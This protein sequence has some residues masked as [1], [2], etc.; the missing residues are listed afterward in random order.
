MGMIAS[1]CGES[2]GIRGESFMNQFLEA[3]RA[4]G[5]LLLGVESPGDGDGETRAFDL[6]FVIVGRDPRSDLQLDAPDV[7]DRH[8]Y[9]QLVGGQL[10]CVDL[11]S[12]IG[13]YH[14]GKCRRISYVER[15]QAVRIGPY[16]IR[17][18]GGD[19]P[20]E[21]HPDGDDD[22][23]PP[24]LVLSH[25][26]VRSSRCP[27][28]VGLSL[29]GS[30]ADCAVRLIDPSVSNYHCSLI[31]TPRGVWLVDLL[32]QGG[33]RVNGQEVGYARLYDGDAVEVGHSVL[34]PDGLPAADLAPAEA[35]P[36]TDVV[37]RNG[38][39]LV[40]DVGG[41]TAASLPIDQAAQLVERIVGPLVTQVGLIQQQ[42]VE[43]LNQARTMMFETFAALHQEQA[44][45]LNHELEQL[46]QL[47]QE[48]HTLRSDLERQTRVLVERTPALPASPTAR[49]G[50]AASAPA[51][52]IR[53]DAPS[54]TKPR[55]NGYSH[56]SVISLT[57]S[58]PPTDRSDDAHIHAL[59]CDRIVRIKQEQQTRWQKILAVLPGSLTGKPTL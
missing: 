57:R 10:V 23:S 30:A 3:C 7:S 32:G 51:V 27:L 45:F 22:R 36:G 52:P 42:M 58:E 41:L 33:V 17:L 12:R 21:A 39:S 1:M 2:R 29:V 47:S 6:P 14:G 38:R 50:S 4:S 56:G 31:R 46:R 25:R 48:L 15:D 8:A 16:R 55:V 34:R 19:A 24:T 20:P 37:V 59:L 44:A 53:L 11:G 43:E 28:P 54:R 13:V 26:S 5:P 18:R 35:S 9:F 40:A 49:L